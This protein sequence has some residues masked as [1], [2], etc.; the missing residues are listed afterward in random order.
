M[1]E[2]LT[3]TRIVSTAVALDH[4][5]GTDA[6]AEGTL[7]FRT[8]ADELLLTPPQHVE[9]IDEY[10]IVVEDTGWC[11]VWIDEADAADFL[12][13]NCTWEVPV[14]RPAFAQ[15]RV[16]DAPV[17]LWLEHDRVLFLVPHVAAHD[18]AKRMSS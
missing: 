1:L 15:G 8:A 12:R 18:L 7:V 3:L 11:G 14:E 6:F 2:P 5:I 17:K 4:V 9:L 10:A 13:N 16:A